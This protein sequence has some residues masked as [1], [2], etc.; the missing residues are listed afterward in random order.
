MLNR[1]LASLNVGRKFALVLAGQILLLILITVLAWLGI[2]QSSSVS[3]Q[4]VQSVQKSKMIGRALNDSNVL[5]TVHISVLGAAKNAAYFA[6]R[7]PRMKEYEDRVNTILQQFPTLPWTDAERPLALKGMARMKDYMD[8]FPALLAAARVRPETEAVPEMME[9]NVGI[10]RE[11]REALEQLQEV[12]LKASEATVQANDRQSH[13]RQAWVL[14]IALAGLLAG[15]GFVRLVALQI[16]GGVKD[17]ERTMSALHQGDLTVRSRV[18]GRDELNHISTSLNLAMVQ[19]RE[20]LQAMAQIAEQNASSATELAATGDQINGATEEISKGA[21]QQRLAVEQS[22]AAMGQMARAMVAARDNAATAERLAQAS[23]L[24][25]GEGLRGAGESTQAM[26]AIRESAQKVSRIT[27]VI[28]EIARQTNLLSLNAAIEAAKAGQ[29]GRGFAVVAEEIRKLAERSGSAAK[30]IFGL[31]QESDQRVLHG[32]EAV[33]AVA[34]SLESIAQDVRH[35]VEQIQSIVQAL[36]VQSRTS[37]EVVQAMDATL[38]FTERNASAT[39]QLASSVTETARTI[40]ELARL[41][42]DLH[43]RINRFRLA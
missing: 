20:D 1:F 28:A 16:T 5:R 43:G 24:A 8:G 12:V 14:G 37:A 19:L 27:T 26:A 32:S 21:D 34:R 22:T 11:A 23:L 42:G 10:Q 9:G 7:T 2:Q 6:K 17:L 39:T 41:A 18:P 40:E 30:E 4:L 13:R 33:A 3:G 29:Q 35:N 25:S 38:T 36:E 31:I 15:V